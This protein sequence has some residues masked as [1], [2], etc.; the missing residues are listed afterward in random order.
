MIKALLS[1]DERIEHLAGEIKATFTERIYAAR[2]EVITAHHETGKLIAEFVEETKY[3][4]ATLITQL[5]QL[6][7]GTETTLFLSHAFYKKFP[8]Q[9]DIDRL[10]QG[11]NISWNK[12]RKAIAPN[13]EEK[14]VEEKT[15]KGFTAVGTMY[16]HR[17]LVETDN[18]DALEQ[19]YQFLK[20]VNSEFIKPKRLVK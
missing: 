12:I 6:G 5:V 2:E 3:K 20:E 8:K 9:S 10:G 19:I 13:T 15:P 17:V 16:G 18:E 14:V 11:K 1:P 4:P 7:A